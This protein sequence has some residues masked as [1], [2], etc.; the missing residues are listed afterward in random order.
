MFKLNFFT[1]YPSLAI[2]SHGRTLEFLISNTHGSFKMSIPCI[3]MTTRFH[4]SCQLFCNWFQHFFSHHWDHLIFQSSVFSSMPSFLNLA[5][6]NLIINH[7]NYS[8]MSTLDFPVPLITWLVSASKI[9]PNFNPMLDLLHTC[10]CADEYGWK[11]P[12][13]FLFYFILFTFMA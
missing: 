2:P 7:Y 9:I 6:W 3:S 5:N 4:L 1:L 8:L 13:K 10:T 12:Y 11:K